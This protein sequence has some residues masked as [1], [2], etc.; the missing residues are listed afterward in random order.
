MKISKRLKARQYDARHREKVK[1]SRRR[2]HIK[3]SDIMHN[4]VGKDRRGSTLSHFTRGT[5]NKMGD[6]MKEVFQK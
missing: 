6:V 2:F 3:E 4:M 1:K 5:F